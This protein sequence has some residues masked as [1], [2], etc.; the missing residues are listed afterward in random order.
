M[1]KIILIAMIALS[2]CSGIEVGG[3]LGVYRV[4]ERSE[5]SRTYRQNVPLKCYFVSCADV[6]G[7]ESRGS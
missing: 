5:Q 7:D 3:K 1:R 2:G 6:Q 4:D